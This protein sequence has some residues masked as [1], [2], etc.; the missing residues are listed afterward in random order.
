M[1]IESDRERENVSLPPPR[2]GG[3]LSGTNNFAG[4]RRTWLLRASISRGTGEYWR[5]REARAAAI[6]TRTRV[7]LPTHR[8]P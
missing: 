3:Q 6:R 8:L 2:P 5:R 1:R 4:L 7:S